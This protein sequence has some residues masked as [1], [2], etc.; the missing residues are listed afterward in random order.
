MANQKSSGDLT[1]CMRCIK[2]NMAWEICEVFS[3]PYPLWGKG[4]CWARETNRNK[5]LK[6]LKQIAEYSRER[7]EEVSGEVVEQIR[8]HKQILDKEI[9]RCFWEDTHRPLHKP[10]KANERADRTHKPNRKKKRRYNQYIEPWTG[11][12]LPP[13]PSAKK[14]KD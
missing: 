13:D 2:F 8:R 12:D 3:K 6:T 9:R 11:F 14:S 4:V 10:P 1:Q 7:G 5:W